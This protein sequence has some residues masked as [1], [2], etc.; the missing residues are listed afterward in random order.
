MFNL[1][2]AINPTPRLPLAV[3]TVDTTLDSNEASYQACTPAINDCSLRGAITK[4]N[5]TPGGIG[6]IN[7]PPNI[8][9]LT[10]V[11]TDDNNV[12]GDLNIIEPVTITGSGQNN[13]FIQAGSSMSDGID[14]VFEVSSEGYVTFSDLTIRW[15]KVT[16]DIVGGAG[17]YQNTITNNIILERVTVTENQTASSQSGGGVYV[18]GSMTIQDSVTPII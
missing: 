10:R 7:V 11:G 9:R 17:I 16:T 4:S 12:A 18:S 13:T 3:I 2:V 6:Y 14:R 5:N 15:G 8:Y 1:A